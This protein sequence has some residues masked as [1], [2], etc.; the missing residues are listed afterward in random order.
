MLTTTQRPEM[1]LR[2]IFPLSHLYCTKA[3]QYGT[4]EMTQVKSSDN[5]RD[6]DNFKGISKSASHHVEK[7]AERSI[8]GSTRE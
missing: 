6:N 5:D 7:A 2:N 1:Q 4:F 8:A 3:C